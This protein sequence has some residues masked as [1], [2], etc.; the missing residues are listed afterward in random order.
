LARFPNGGT[1]A[2]ALEIASR[3]RDSPIT[4]HQ[5]G[6]WQSHNSDFV[7]AYDILSTRLVDW[8]KHLAMSLEA[9]NAVKA[10]MENRRLLDMPWEDLDSRKST[11]KAQAAQGALE[12]VVGK[13]ERVDVTV[14]RIEDLL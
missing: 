8:Q 9:G 2:E 12:R 11:A 14:V 3:R 13:H 6:A 7:R 5:L 1:D 4:A 10:A